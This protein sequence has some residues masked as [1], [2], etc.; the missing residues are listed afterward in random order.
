M[1]EKAE[2]ESV[3]SEAIQGQSELDLYYRNNREEVKTLI[4]KF[5][6]QTEDIPTIVELLKLID[7][8]EEI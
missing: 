8:I 6:I 7:E 5:Q 2:L 3:I 1:E 4:M